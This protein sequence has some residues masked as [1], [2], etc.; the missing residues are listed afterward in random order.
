LT[1]VDDEQ[2]V[3]FGVF[4]FDPSALQLRKAH[5]P[6]RLRPQALKLLRIFVSHPRQ[7]IPREMIQR[8]L[9]GVDVHVDFEQGVNHIIKQLRAALG[10]DANAPR[11]IET[12]P[13]LGYRFIAPVDALPPVAVSE[14][15]AS[16]GISMTQR[17]PSVGRRALLAAAATLVIAGL[18]FAFLPQPRD[19][20]AALP[21]NSTLAVIPFDVA[22]VEG[23][24]EHLGLSLADAVIARV[25]TGGGI[26]V[27]PVATTRQYDQGSRDVRAVDHPRIQGSPHET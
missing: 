10:D 11:Y 4:D 16:D 6:V 19:P 2:I 25:S 22:D 12:V 9:W 7:L 20:P 18:S 24:P 3:R 27:R 26:R 23:K 1:V 8:E 14:H 13:R 21:A 15:A 5:R 17:R